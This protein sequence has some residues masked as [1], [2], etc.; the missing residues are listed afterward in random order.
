MTGTSKNGPT[1]DVFAAVAAELDRLAP[2]GVLLDLDDTLYAYGPCHAA[3]LRLC[4]E[5]FSAAGGTLTH[6]SF[7]ERYAA[8]REL[9]KETTRG[10]AASH[11]RLLYLQ[12]LLE[13]LGGRTDVGLT[14]ELETAYWDGFTCAIELRPGA[15]AFLE[16]LRARGI[17]VAVVSDLTARIQ[18]EKLRK[19]DLAGLVD[20]LV[21]SEE[22]GADKP[23]PEIFRLALRKLGLEPQDV[24]LIG[25]DAEKDGKGGE[26]LG[27]RTLIISK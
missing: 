26:G 2:R 3:G 7:C 13:G 10:Q 21:S 14:L 5:K 9:V 1:P 17:P 23:A 25:D 15:R 12:R 20:F 6:E 27:I 24:V 8:A 22:A 11:S 18:L 19:M 16:R 4:H